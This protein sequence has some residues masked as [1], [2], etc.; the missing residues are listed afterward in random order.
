MRTVHAPPPPA[1]S[2]PAAVL[3][4]PSCG[5]SIPA[6]HRFC[7]SCGFAFAMPA[8]AT[9]AKRPSLPPLPVSPVVRDTPSTAF[10]ERQGTVPVPPPSTAAPLGHHCLACGCEISPLTRTCHACGTF[11][12][13]LAPN[14]M[15]VVVP[16]PPSS[17]IGFGSRPS[18]VP[19]RPLARTRPALE[20]LES[21]ESRV[22]PVPEPAPKPEPPR[23]SLVHLLPDGSEKVVAS[24]DG[25]LDVGRRVTDVL[26]DDRF[27]S[28]RHARFTADG[29]RLQVRDLD[30][31]NG[32]FLR[33]AADAT[34]ALSSGDVV[35]LGAQVLRFDALDGATLAGAVDGDT[36]VFGSPS[37]PRYGRLVEVTCEG[38]PRSTY[39]IGMETVSVGRELADLIFGDDP[40]LSRRHAQFRVVD[41]H[42]L[43]SDL[44]S[45]N[46]T[47][48]RIRGEA[49]LASG[50]QLR[51]GQQRFRVQCAE[52]RGDA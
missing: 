6:S 27:V 30:S 8:T 22:E 17:M 23:W 9:P 39:V 5:A 52:N 45:S 34:A 36:S 46:G 7:G 41:G 29:D 47:Y 48:V 49:S 2:L 15:E 28:P 1:P 3:S 51:I 12:V 50:A 16:P 38:T 19:A 33:I 13:H 37:K 11:Q 25:A 21:L 43:L 35:L 10:A 24:I 32:V 42:V 44:G 20:S 26:A 4:C 18:S 14:A 40:H 31:A